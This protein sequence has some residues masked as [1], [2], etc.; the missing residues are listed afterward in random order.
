MNWLY[1]LQ[2]K[3]GRF[4]IDNLMIYI[5]VTMLAIYL[6]D[7]F[8]RIGIADWLYFSRALILQG[9]VWR[10]ITFIFVPPA[11]SPIF[12]LFSLYFYY[13]V[14][15]SLEKTW[16]AFQF[17]FYYL[18][19]IVGT[20]IA[21]FLTGFASNNYLNLS[22]FF[23]FAQL[24]PDHQVLL[25]FFIP[26]K[27]KYLAYV[28]WAFFGIS[29]MTSIIRLDFVT[30]A[31]ILASLVNFFIFFGPDFIDRFRDWRRYGKQRRDWKK[32]SRNNN[33]DFWR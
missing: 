19:G 8:I 14:G 10:L 21:G 23:A 7:T 15:D 20:I 17:T 12:I 2:R 29:L 26:I 1:K 18:C 24:F 31:S 30:C 27:I 28:N 6:M 33:N 11:A 25:F 4:G 9:Q 3:F 13:F 32:Q 5:T 22:L 16:G